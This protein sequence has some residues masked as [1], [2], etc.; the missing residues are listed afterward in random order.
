MLDSRHKELVKQGDKLFSGR[1]GLESL[2][3]EIA[4]HFYPERA[5]FTATHSL[6]DEFADHLTTSY[7]II[8]RRELG[9]TF[10]A[11]LRP[12]E[13][14]WFFV[15]AM[16]EDR[17]APDDTEGRAW[18]EWATGLQR[19][20]MYDIESGFV[21]ATKQADHDF[22]AFGQTPLSMELNRDGDGLLCRSWHLK[23]VAWAEGYNGRVNTTH[24]RF[25]QE[26]RTLNTTFRGDV[27]PKVKDKVKKDP[28]A[29]IECRHIVVPSE[30]YE[31]RWRTPYVSV[32]IDMENQHV[33]Q[34]VGSWTPIYVIPRW[35][36]V[37]GSQYAYSPATVAALPDARL[38]QAMTL[39]LLEAGEK[40]ADPPT[41]ATREAVRSDLDTRAGGVTW[42]DSEYDERLGEA[43][44]PL[45]IDRSGLSFGVEMHDRIR[46]AITE[47]FYLNKLSMP[48]AGTGDMTA[49]EVGQRIQEYIRNA[50]PIFEPVETDYNGELCEQTFEI[51]LRN[52]AF[53]PPQTIPESLQGEE[54]TFRFESPLSQMAERQKGQEFMEAKAITLDTAQFEP[55]A[56]AMLDAKTAL[57]DV[58]TGIGTPA[59]WLRS[60]EQVA[61]IEQQNLEAAQQTAQLGILREGAAMAKD[62]GAAAQAGAGAVET[63]SPE[64]APA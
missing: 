60:E 34:E 64:Q 21:R 45:N 58:L 7:P 47:A 18:L 28:F 32:Y 5:M 1:S 49:F 16:R 2:W 37:S 20:A 15:K 43:L 62:L 3:Q 50:L 30:E 39:T 48:P 33:M 38:I 53:G 31:G 6:G 54:T 10:S 63:L 22:A 25:K 56:A 14:P 19:R 24:R 61:A 51:L 12:K 8:A 44:R 23:D 52:G 13:T 40:A 46:V 9:N 55:G 26:L 35:Q 59:K 11:M 29:E 36:T 42:V 17:M 27:S 57:R 4:E 41:V